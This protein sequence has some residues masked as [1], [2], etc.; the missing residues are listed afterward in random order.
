MSSNFGVATFFVKL[1]QARVGGV[2]GGADGGTDGHAPQSSGQFKH[3]S[4]P[5]QT[6]FPQDGDT[7]GGAEGDELGLGDAEAKVQLES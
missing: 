4:L 2:D 3:V 1:T 5:L 6:P 7:D